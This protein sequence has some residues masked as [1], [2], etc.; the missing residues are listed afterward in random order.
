MLHVYYN[1]SLSVSK[2]RSAKDEEAVT[3]ESWCRTAAPDDD[4]APMVARRSERS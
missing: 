2:C 3:G 1:V 4:D